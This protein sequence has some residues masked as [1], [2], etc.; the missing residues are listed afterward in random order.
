VEID[1]IEIGRFSK[2]TPEDLGIKPEHDWSAQNEVIRALKL[3]D[4]AVTLEPP[5]GFT[6]QHMR[7]LLLTNARKHLA[8][9][10]VRLTTRLVELDGRKALRCFLM[11]RTL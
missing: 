2:V 3:G 10:P 1:G 11:P 5:P 6:I 8:G 4:K 7:K 9:K